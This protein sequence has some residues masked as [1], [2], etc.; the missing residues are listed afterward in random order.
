[1]RNLELRK[2]NHLLRD[3]WLPMREQ[4]FE[5]GSVS[6][7]STLPLGSVLGSRRETP[8]SASSPQ[9]HHWTQAGKPGSGTSWGASI[10]AKSG[11]E[12]AAT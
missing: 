10:E 2:L 7:L 1:M 9:K 6:A 3:T 4:R 12:G 5:L 8:P 11:K